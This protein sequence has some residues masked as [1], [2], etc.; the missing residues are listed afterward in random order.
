MYSV[1]KKNKGKARRQLEK[2][3]RAN[4]GYDSLVEMVEDYVHSHA[5]DKFIHD[6]A[7]KLRDKYL[8]GVEF[9]IR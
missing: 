2:R 5:D 6:F 1:S 4:I 3:L 8:G 7:E 9:T